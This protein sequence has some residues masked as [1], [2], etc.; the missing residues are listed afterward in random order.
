MVS[1][2]ANETFLYGVDTDKV[3]SLIND[4]NEN[5]KYFNDTASQIASEQTKHLDELM[6]K[7]YLIVRKPDDVDTTVL[8]NYYLEL[9][10]L[11]YFM[12]DKLEQLGVYSD[13]SKAAAKEVYNSA[14]LSNQIKDVDKKNKTTVAENQAVAEQKSQYEQVVNSIYEHAYK[15]VKYK[16][17]AGF[18]MINTLRKVISRRMQ[19]E[20]LGSSRFTAM[21]LSRAISRVGCSGAQSTE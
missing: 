4:T 13:M 3:S 17:D 20:N 8:E 5:V 9:T 12:G 18:E 15:I 14:Y 10:N 21:R 19:E 7:L 1:S 11:L 6:Q 2:L 16:I